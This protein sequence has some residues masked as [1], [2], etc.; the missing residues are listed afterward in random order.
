VVL[1]GLEQ[2]QMA[3][4]TFSPQSSSDA[5]H[6]QQLALAVGHLLQAAGSIVIGL[7]RSSIRLSLGYSMLMQLHGCLWGA[8]ECL[9][10]F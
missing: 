1:V 4:G 7:C 6:L 3:A 8:A 2:Q 10:R 5:Q 9:R